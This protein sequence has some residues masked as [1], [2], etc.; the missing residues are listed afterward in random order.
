MPR[1]PSLKVRSRELVTRVGS[2]RRL[3]AHARE[4]RVGGVG[5]LHPAC[6]NCRRKSRPREVSELFPSSSAEYR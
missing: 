4:K 6:G 2:S 1:W 3:A 5:K